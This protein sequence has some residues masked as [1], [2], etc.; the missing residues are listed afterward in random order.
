MLIL[1]FNVVTN[2]K[3]DL[4]KKQKQHKSCNNSVAM[5]LLLAITYKHNDQMSKKLVPS[6]NMELDFIKM[7]HAGS[8]I[9]KKIEI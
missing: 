5:T 8:K 4:R 3:L 9:V 6:S 1:M 2:A 7:L